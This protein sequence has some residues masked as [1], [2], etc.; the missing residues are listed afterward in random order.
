MTGISTHRA[1]ILKSALTSDWR[2]Q[3]HAIITGLTEEVQVETDRLLEELEAAME[4]GMT[5]E[6]FDLVLQTAV[7]NITFKRRKP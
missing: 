7:Q 6:E 1:M 5:M 2:A 3:R 4:D